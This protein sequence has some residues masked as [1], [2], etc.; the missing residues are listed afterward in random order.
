VTNRRPWGAVFRVD[1]SHFHVVLYCWDIVTLCTVVFGHFRIILECCDRWIF[2][3]Q[4]LKLGN[5]LK[6]RRHLVGILLLLKGK[7]SV[8]LSLFIRQTCC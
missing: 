1:F 4:R 3:L 8:G 6:T 5:I 7:Q 2:I